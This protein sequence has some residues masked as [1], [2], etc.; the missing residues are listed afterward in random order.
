[1]KKVNALL[2]EQEIKRLLR[3]TESKPNNID[4]SASRAQRLLIRWGRSVPAA[5]VRSSSVESLTNLR[6]K[7]SAATATRAG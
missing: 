7:T 6:V 4:I 2:D 5:M 3:K 1:M